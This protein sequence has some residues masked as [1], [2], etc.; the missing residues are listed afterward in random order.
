[1]LHINNDNVLKPFA[2]FQSLKNSPN[3]TKQF[4]F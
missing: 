2:L 3:N 4:R 1:M